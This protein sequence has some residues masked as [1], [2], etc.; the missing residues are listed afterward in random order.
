M[1][2][3]RVNLKLN[4]RAILT[5]TLPYE[6]PLFFSNERLF[7]ATKGDSP[8]SGFPEL[9]K[10]I[11]D[12]SK[13]TRPFNYRIHKG[14]G[15]S[16]QLSIPH[17]AAQLDIARF[18]NDFDGFI[19]NLCGRSSFSLRYPSRVGSHY[20]ETQF[21]NATELFEQSEADADPTSFN[22]QRKWAST[23]FSYRNYTQMHRFFSSPEFIRLEQRNEFLLQIDI[24]KCFDSIYSHSIC[25]AVRGKEFSKRNIRARAFE[26]TFDSLMHNANWSETNGILVGPE[27][28]RIFAEIILQEIDCR[29]EGALA[30]LNLKVTVRRYI[31]DYMIF[32]NVEG[33][34]LKCKRLIEEFAG[35]FNLHLNETKTVLTTRPLVTQ[36][37][38]ARDAIH[39]E[40]S[41]FFKLAAAALDTSQ[42]GHFPI[43]AAEKSI[44]AIRKIAREYEVSYARLASPALAVIS[45]NLHR[46]RRRCD[47]TPA[48]GRGPKHSQRIVS[49]TLKLAHFLYHMDI[50]M[51]TTHKIALI[52]YEVA[53]L[54]RKLGINVEVL[55]SQIIAGMRA[56]IDRARALEIMGPELINL[57]VAVE[58]VCRKRSPLTVTDLAMALNAMPDWR[59]SV[60]HMNYFD[61]MAILYFS[62]RRAAFCDARAAAVAEIERRILAVGKDLMYRAS[63]AL[64]FFDLISCPYV[65]ADAKSDLFLKVNQSIGSRITP[66]TAAIQSAFLSSTMGFTSWDGARNLHALLERKELQ[67]AYD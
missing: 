24:S 63:E 67:L 9:A 54:A 36:L 25:W 31:D 18:Y 34:L 53:F 1:S 40:L 5:D 47:E 10:K 57:L 60:K 55:E 33:D 4:N 39:L 7:N 48:G 28:S 22:T 59:M 26:A 14:G 61:L 20:F 35:E 21:S 62:K 2:K 58:A 46:I 8:F 11:L 12:H 37:T 44:S 65:S 16:R 49:E 43:D 3:V 66:A 56:A 30:E 15:A 41:R 29:V 19:L 50:R 32:G 64:M 27:F 13:A 23:H 52:Y 45:R 38:I 6:T 17:P 42:P 51:A